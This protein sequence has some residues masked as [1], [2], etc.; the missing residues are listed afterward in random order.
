MYRKKQYTQQ[1]FD[2][3]LPTLAQSI[4]S[5]RN[6]DMKRIEVANLFTRPPPSFEV[7]LR[8]FFILL[9]N[10]SISNLPW[11][12][13]QMMDLPRWMDIKLLLR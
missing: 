6:L 3:F 13:Q 4:D 12:R 2:L 7:A 11:G 1:M 8:P 10:K 9:T 5:V